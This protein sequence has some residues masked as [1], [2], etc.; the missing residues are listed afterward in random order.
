MYGEG[1]VRGGHWLLLVSICQLLSLSIVQVAS[2][3]AFDDFF[4]AYRD[5]HPGARAVA[6]QIYFYLGLNV[7]CWRAVVED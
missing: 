5:G 4:S 6:K 3:L 2:A 1:K 7:S